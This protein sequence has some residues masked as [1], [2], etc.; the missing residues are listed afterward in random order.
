[1][2]DAYRKNLGEQSG[3]EEGGMLDDYIVALILVRHVQLV[4]QVVCGLAHL[5]Q[6]SAVNSRVSS[7]QCIKPFR[8][9]RRTGMNTAHC[10]TVLH[11][12]V[13]DTSWLCVQGTSRI[14]MSRWRIKHD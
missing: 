4:Q 2:V 8:L 1:M 14:Y 3:G 6:V 13:R 11:I 9:V 5:Q 7:R 10:Y 12:V